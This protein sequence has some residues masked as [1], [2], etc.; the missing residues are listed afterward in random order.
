MS[1]KKIAKNINNLI[2]SLR[3]NVI[4]NYVDYFVICES[5]FNHQNIEKKIN[6][7]PQKKYIN[8]KKVIHIVLKK[9]FPKTTNAWENHKIALLCCLNNS[10]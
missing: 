1:F 5:A 2:R 7:D 8:D 9:P 4:K 6:F 3:Y 10:N